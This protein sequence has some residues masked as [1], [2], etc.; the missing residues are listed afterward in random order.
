VANEL[1][2]PPFDFAEDEIPKGFSIDYIRLLAEKSGLKLEFVNGYSW[3]ELLQQFKAGHIDIMPAI[4]ES[5][6]RKKDMDFTSSYYSQ[7]SVILVNSNNHKITTINDLKGKKLAAIKGF[8]ITNE[9]AEQ[10]P[11]INLIFFDILLDAVMSVS[12]G[13]TDALIDSIGVLS[14]LRQKNFIPNISF[15]QDKQLKTIANPSLHIAIKKDHSLLLSILNKS[16]QL[17]P[18]SEMQKL[19]ERWLKLSETPSQ[20]RSLPTNQSDQQSNTWLTY[21][22]ILM[23]VVIALFIFYRLWRSHGEKKTA[24]FSLFILL[25]LLIGGS[26]YSFNLYVQN[27]ELISNAKN[28]R[29]QSLKLVDHLRQTSDDLT[30]MARTYVVTGESR[31][32][33]YFHQILDIR[34]GKRARPVKYDHIYWDFVTASGRRPQGGGTAVSLEALM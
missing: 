20:S 30:R 19:T 15:I 8:V 26:L 2:W 12:T 32:E 3:D 14:Y 28:N 23:S 13:Q 29:Y 17:I 6:E 24:M 1:D 5:D 16:M 25:L 9:V 34:N 27:V 18:Q 7:P 33:D 10:Y 11:E 22:F 4:Y 31:Y 21:I